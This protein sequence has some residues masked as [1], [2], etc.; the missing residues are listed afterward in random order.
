MPF[1][2]NVTCEVAK[3]VKIRKVTQRRASDRQYF[4]GDG[5]V[6]VG[7]AAFKAVVR[8]AERLGCVRF[9]C[10]SAKIY[11]SPQF[12]GSFLC[13]SKHQCYAIRRAT[14][15]RDDNA[16]DKRPKNST[17]SQQHAM[18]RAENPHNSIN[19]MPRN[20]RGITQ[21]KRLPQTLVTVTYC[22]TNCPVTPTTTTAAIITPMPRSSL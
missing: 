7:P 11:K 9:A 1:C 2:G 6:L 20:A 21:D 19:I 4:N 14:R 10:I 8:R 16:I 13:D 15:S 12:R 22:R 5:W 3:Y 17:P 18:R